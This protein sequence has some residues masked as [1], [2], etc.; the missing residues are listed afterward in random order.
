MMEKNIVIHIRFRNSHSPRIPIIKDIELC[1]SLNLTL[2][3]IIRLS[4]KFLLFYHHFY[5]MC[6]RNYM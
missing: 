1:K 6:G 2:I 5:S 4:L 3:I